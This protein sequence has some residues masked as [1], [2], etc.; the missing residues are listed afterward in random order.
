MFPLRVAV[1]VAMLVAG[2]KVMAGRAT[3]VV[4]FNDADGHAVPAELAAEA[5][6]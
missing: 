1:V 4:K 5:E 6:K 2:L 3:K